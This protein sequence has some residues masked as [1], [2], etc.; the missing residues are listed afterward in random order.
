M[1]V[2]G[3]QDRTQVLCVIADRLNVFRPKKSKIV[4]SFALQL[5]LHDVSDTMCTAAIHQE[6]KHSLK[7]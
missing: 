7:N 4:R 6:S 2:N 1:L 5:K 3:M